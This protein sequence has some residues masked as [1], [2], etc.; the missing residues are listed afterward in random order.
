MRSA[1]TCDDELTVSFLNVCSIQRK[2]REVQEFLVGGHAHGPCL[3]WYNWSGNVHDP[4]R[5]AALQATHGPL[6][7]SALTSFQPVSVQDVEKCLACVNPNRASGSDCSSGIVLQCCAS[8]LAPPLARIIN[9]SLSS[10]TVPACFKL[11]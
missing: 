5:P 10:G 8:V 11:S 3:S 2:V 9:M 1:T 4:A 6:Q 7:Q